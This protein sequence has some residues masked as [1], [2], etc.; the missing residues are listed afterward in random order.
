MPASSKKTVKR[1]ARSVN[2]P[3]NKSDSGPEI[4]IELLEGREGASLD[5]PFLPDE[6]EIKVI[7]DRNDQKKTFPL[8]EVCCIMQRDDPNHLSTLQSDYDLLEIEFAD[9]LLKDLANAAS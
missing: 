3:Q 9:Q 1:A 4:L 2:G 6:N 7:L 5:K 8:F